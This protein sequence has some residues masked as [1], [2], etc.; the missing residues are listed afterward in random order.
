[1]TQY[2]AKQARLMLKQRPFTN[3]EE[4]CTESLGNDREMVLTY[5]ESALQDEEFEYFWRSVRPSVQNL[6]FSHAAKRPKAVGLD[7]PKGPK[8]YIYTCLL[9]KVNKLHSSI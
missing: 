6:K 5:L 3:F 1:M 7:G 9:G 2:D 8:Q 4:N